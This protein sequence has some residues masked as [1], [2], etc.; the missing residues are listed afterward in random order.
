M[1]AWEEKLCLAFECIY[2]N[3]CTKWIENIPDETESLFMVMQPDLKKYTCYVPMD[4][5]V[6]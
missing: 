2:K 1:P 3:T 4:G 5:K 6:L